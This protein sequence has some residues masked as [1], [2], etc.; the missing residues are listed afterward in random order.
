MEEDTIACSLANFIIKQCPMARLRWMQSNE[1]QKK[2]QQL[3]QVHLQSPGKA[4]AMRAI[5]MDLLA[6]LPLS[7]ARSPIAWMTR[8]C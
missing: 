7:L 5:V 2:Q 3:Q 1:L 6:A 4:K 8:N